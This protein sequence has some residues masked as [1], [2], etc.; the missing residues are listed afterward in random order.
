MNKN[1]VVAIA[2]K[3]TFTNVS[4]SSEEGDMVQGQ[5]GSCIFILSTVEVITN[6]ITVNQ[7]TFTNCGGV[8]D[9]GAIYAELQGID[10]SGCKFV[11]CYSQSPNK[12]DN[13]GAV[14]L[15]G[16]NAL[17]YEMF[18]GNIFENC[19]CS[20]AGGAL[21]V[22][23]HDKETSSKII[24]ESDQDQYVI[25]I[26]NCNFTKC[27]SG[28]EGGAISSGI[29][30]EQSHSWGDNDMRLSTCHFIECESKKG[31]A[32]F[33]QDGDEDGDE[34]TGISSCYFTNC[35]ASSGE[36]Y[37]ISCRSYKLT[38]SY[39]FFYDH[40]R[41]V[42]SPN[43]VTPSI[44]YI[45]MD[46]TAP[47]V[48]DLTFERNPQVSALTIITKSP[49]T[50]ERVN[51]ND[52]HC[53]SYSQHPCI[54]LDSWS[55]K[56]T[57]TLS[58]CRFTNISNVQCISS[59][60]TNFETNVTSCEFKNI[61]AHL[62][63]GYILQYGAC[64]A[65]L[66]SRA[67]LI[68]EDSS[69]TEVEVIEGHGGAI[70]A[71]A[72]SLDIKQCKFIRC[73]VSSSKSE[74]S[75]DPSPQG[76]AI[77]LDASTG[78]EEET[79]QNC[80]FENCTSIYSGGAIF[81]YC[82][83]QNVSLSNERHAIHIHYCNFT[84]CK[85]EVEGGAISSGVKLA[86]RPIEGD[87]DFCISYCHFVECE[88]GR[89]GALY[90]QDGTKDGDEETNIHNC[91]FINCYSSGETHEGY[92]IYCR[93]YRIN[94][95]GCVFR[96]H[97]RGNDAKTN[98]IVY[99]ETNE[100]DVSPSIASLTFDDN[101]GV[102][103]LVVKSKMLTTIS[104]LVFNNTADNSPCINLDNWATEKNVI[105][106]NSIFSN[107]INARCI[108][109]LTLT[110]TFQGIVRNCQFINNRVVK[111]QRGEY[112]SGCGASI[113]CQNN[114]N[115]FISHC[116]FTNNL[117]EL[118]G[119]AVYAETN[120]IELSLCRFELCAAA[121]Y[122]E[123]GRGGALYL[124]QTASGDFEFSS[125][126]VF[127]NC[128]ASYSGGG[129]YIYCRDVNSRSARE[130]DD[131][132]Y[133]ILVLTCNFTNCSSG[134]EGGAL[135]SGLVN[136]ETESTEGDN[137]LYIA[138]C[139]FRC[140]ESVKGG[141]L[142]FQDGTLE[143]DEET[144]INLCHFYDCYATG[145]KHEGYAIHCRSYRI[146]IDTCEFFYHKPRKDG[147]SGC[148]VYV[149]TNEADVTPNLST[150]LFND[151]HNIPSIVVRSKQSVTL[152]TSV[153]SSSPL[154][155]NDEWDVSEI[156]FSGCIFQH[157][158]GEKGGSVYISSS[159]Q[160]SRSSRQ[161][162]ILSET[163][164]V[165]QQCQFVNSTAKQGG[166]IYADSITELVLEECAFY[167]STASEN[168]G[169]VYTSV[170]SEISKCN[171]SQT[172]SPKGAAIF[173]VLD[174]NINISDITLDIS[175]E[176]GVS[177]ILVSG[178]NSSN[179][180]SFSGSGC[181]I[182]SGKSETDK[183]ADFIE[184]ESEGSLS[185]EGDM[186]FSGS[187]DESI[188]LPPGSSI[189]NKNWFNCDRCPAP[190]PPTVWNP[191][192]G[193]PVKPTP[194]VNTSYTAGPGDST[195]VT[196]RS[197]SKL[198]AGAIAGIV[199]GCVAFVAIILFIILFF[200]LRR[201]NVPAPNPTEIASQEVESVFNNET[202]NQGAASPF[203][204]QEI[205]VNPTLSNDGYADQGNEDPFVREF[206]E[207]Y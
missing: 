109:T 83:D 144:H 85:S 91:T 140:C 18:S 138:T 103:G 136:P 152:A 81:V 75:E 57:L 74:S 108:T 166:A 42:E 188:K 207:G 60:I 107:I 88:S 34:E 180:V 194:S 102:S 19:S 122:D 46:E 17:S 156:L 79:I 189:N 26:F 31:G 56:D 141:A 115:L 197:K 170:Q 111:S 53:E 6:N 50:L 158:S 112:L 124:N 100:E 172:T 14:S 132:Q 5:C 187:L 73:R 128:T 92:S 51:F 64:I 84:H 27:K 82:Y 133:Q 70:Y 129:M 160:S 169:A 15:V 96:L 28:E 33:F 69:F 93:S 62:S 117:A 8:G 134:V 176:E 43:G 12:M 9:G 182:S 25:R 63:P 131:N 3:C 20:R 205:N 94:M 145:E 191:S 177:A 167:N 106:E 125:G 137:D 66:S 95:T 71:L 13:G 181:F 139:Y 98:C 10:I 198:S 90:F 159:A 163:R 146:Y 37:A 30:D 29:I 104:H 199:V 184:F 2:Q 68:V 77:Y 40:T 44:V 200:V 162:K 32:I 67:N 72:E 130:D 186:C 155:I 165:F 151:N 202:T 135:S 174:N 203:W 97:K 178:G 148:I 11:N 24:R 38:M 153:F 147:E 23:C 113:L 49:T 105:I 192:D 121:P 204:T 1:S 61:S 99:V 175:K 87:D 173:A 183:S 164:F 78:K 149:E 161:T 195:D 7:C 196:T 193:A 4:L 123:D 150:L 157:N 118:H 101:T 89:G 41:T 22:F 80:T 171:F 154:H 47:M 143:G 126:N 179:K 127:I 86:N 35:Y 21:Y 114:G 65:S 168:G 59:I 45:N 36:G 16:F 119:G 120:A 201:G 48:S 206:E 39:S 76:G 142:Y 52:Y 190:P 185:I 58:G 110:Q 116:N 55:I 54:S